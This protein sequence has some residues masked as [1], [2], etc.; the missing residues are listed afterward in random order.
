M[1]PNLLCVAQCIPYSKFLYVA[2]YIQ[3]AKSLHHIILS[4]VACLAVKY[5]ST[6]SHKQ[7]DFSK[8]VFVHKLDVFISSTTFLKHFSF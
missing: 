2:L 3:H 5:F 1:Q 6:L 4:S 8:K 7:H